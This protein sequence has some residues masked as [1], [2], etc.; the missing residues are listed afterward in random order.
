MAVFTNIKEN[1]HTP[2]SGIGVLLPAGARWSADR[3]S[4]V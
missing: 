2:E 3:K 4:V 1:V